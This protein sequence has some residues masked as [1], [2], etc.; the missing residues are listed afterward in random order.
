MILPILVALA[1]QSSLPPN[2]V[3][4]STVTTGML[5]QECRQTQGT[6]MGF[7]T[8]YILG[9]ADALQLDH[10]TC[11]P[12]SDVGTLQTVEIVRRY[13]EAHPE[14]WSIHAL[15]IV[16]WALIEAFPCPRRR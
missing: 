4:V 1:A 11:R 12:N 3:S 14:Q 7:C 9:V 15:V 13:L 5:V 2:L 6:V 16:R 8:G 10:R